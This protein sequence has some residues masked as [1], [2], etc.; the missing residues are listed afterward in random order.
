MNKI[1]LNHF[2]VTRFLSPRRQ[3]KIECATRE[4]LSPF[5]V[6]PTPDFC[7]HTHAYVIGITSVFLM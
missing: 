7:H 6:L 4:R 1:Q 5:Y 3:K 2:V